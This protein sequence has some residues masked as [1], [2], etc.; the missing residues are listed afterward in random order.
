MEA[1]LRLKQDRVTSSLDAMAAACLIER[2]IEDQGEYS[3]LAEP[4]EYPPPKDLSMLD[5]S[6]V[7]AHVKRI[8]AVEYTQADINKIKMIALKVR[9][10]KNIFYKQNIHI[11]II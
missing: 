4:C 6:K 1:K 2:Y 10:K 8:N 9:V 3:I 11:F 7:A 5:Y